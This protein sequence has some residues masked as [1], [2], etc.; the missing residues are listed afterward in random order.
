MKRQSVLP[1]VLAGLA[2]ILFAVVLGLSGGT[3]LYEA[4]DDAY[5]PSHKDVSAVSVMTTEE[6]ETIL[7]LMAEIMLQSSKISLE[8]D[9]KD[10]AYSER[11]LQEYAN[12]IKRLKS[13]NAKINLGNTELNDFRIS[14]E[15]LNIAL[16]VLNS[17]VA[18]MEEIKQEI[19]D[20][21]VD[22][23]SLAALYSEM[24]ALSKEIT[25]TAETYSQTADKVIE[26]AKKQDLDTSHMDQAVSTVNKVAANALSSLPST[27][28]DLPI[29]FTIS[30]DTFVYGDTLL[31]EGSSKLSGQHE[32]YLDTRVWGTVNL[33]KPGAFTKSF[34]ITNISK[35]LHTISI[36]SQGKVSKQDTITILTTNTSVFISSA[37]VSGNTVTITGGLQTVNE[38]WVSGAKVDVYADGIGLLGTN[39]TNKNGVFTIQTELEDGVYQVYAEF[40][41][42]SFPLERSV[43]EPFTVKVSQSF[44]LPILGAAVLGVAAFIGIRIFRKRKTSALPDNTEFEVTE[45]N[46]V[47]P[48]ATQKIVKKIRKIIS[49][50]AKTGDSDKLRVLYHETISVIS[51]YEGISNTEVK[52]PREI[53][54]EI[55][56]VTDDIGEFIT[57]YE[58]L[59]YAYIEIRESDLTKM[60]YIAKKI[61]ETYHEN[62]E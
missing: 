33:N 29:L 40:S 32:I 42:V 13:N 2:L 8:I 18:R 31:I 43:S 55:G 1:F 7:P 17:D 51:H 3:V 22:A 5:S 28:S 49:G 19:R 52:T 16:E 37:K 61:Q 45:L 30:D 12:L 27:P 38:V 14:A 62:K 11:E 58:Y 10:F 44:L 25:L 53:L 9:A 21:S 56:D 50:S 26:T 6:A 20:G 34:K 59:H 60:K 46:V 48:T 54:R 15:E 35:G 39:V 57:E 24:Q 23:S 36:Q 47:K 4:S 41:D